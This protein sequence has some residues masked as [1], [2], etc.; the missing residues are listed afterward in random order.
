[1]KHINRRQTCIYALLLVLVAISVGATL[2]GRPRG[3]AAA[4][5]GRMSP[6]PTPVKE[7]L[8]LTILHS[9]QVYGEILPCG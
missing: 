6:A 8:S 4:G 5:P 9:G 1:M 7:P 2:R 3:R